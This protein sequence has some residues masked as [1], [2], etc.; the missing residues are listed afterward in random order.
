LGGRQ[1]AEGQK[2]DADPARE[3]VACFEMLRRAKRRRVCRLHPWVQA[4]S[5][6]CRAV[7]IQNWLAFLS[8][9]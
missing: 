3:I 9:T 4:K 2:A 8:I 6:E 1:G 5:P 7:Q